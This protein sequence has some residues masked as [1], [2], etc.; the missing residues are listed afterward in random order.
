MADSKTPLFQAQYFRFAGPKLYFIDIEQQ[1][2]FSENKTNV[3]VC[4][5]VYSF[6]VFDGSLKIENRNQFSIFVFRP[7]HSKSFRY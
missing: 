7:K 1:F 4:G 2:F 3:T 5:I 6:F